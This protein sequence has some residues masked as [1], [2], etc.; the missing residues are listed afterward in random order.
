MKPRRN[1]PKTR[2]GRGRS[3]FG[4]ESYALRRRER[5]LARELFRAHRNFEPLT[6][7]FARIA[8]ATPHQVGGKLSARAVGEFES[9]FAAARNSECRRSSRLALASPRHLTLTPVMGEREARDRR[10]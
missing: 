5:G 4:F 2:V 1:G 8:L 3:R 6:H 10:A 9:T 7:P